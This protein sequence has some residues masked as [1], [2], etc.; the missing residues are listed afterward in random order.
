MDAEEALRVAVLD[1]A[2]RADIRR[3]HALLDELVRVVA[4]DRHDVVDLAVCVEDELHLVALEGD[5]A[6][7]LSLHGERLVELVEIID[8]LHDVLIL[9]AEGLIALN[10]GEDLG[11]GEAG[12]RS[13]DRGIKLVG[14]DDALP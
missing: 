11:V 2:R 14:L 8:A 4:L 13:H 1:E 7:R 10:H 12:V 9:L 6:P 3:D 5:G